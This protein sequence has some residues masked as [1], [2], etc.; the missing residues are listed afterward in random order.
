M[1]INDKFRLLLTTTLRDDGLP[2]DR[3]YD[4]QVSKSASVK[5]M[6]LHLI[7][8]TED[9]HFWITLLYWNSRTEILSTTFLIQVVL[10]IQKNVLQ[11]G[12]K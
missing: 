10:A 8:F 7:S 4:P 1:H 5:K 6:V 11:L 12:C 2:D 3:V 9:S